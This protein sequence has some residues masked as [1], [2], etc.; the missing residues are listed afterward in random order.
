MSL[1]DIEIVGRVCVEKGKGKL[2]WNLRLRLACL[3]LRRAWKRF[4]LDT[5][6]FLDTLDLWLI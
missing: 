6:S 4:F 2:T 1:N 3:W 5:D